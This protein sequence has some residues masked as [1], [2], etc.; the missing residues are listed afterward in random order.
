[1]IIQF[2]LADFSDCFGG[3]LGQHIGDCAPRQKAGRAEKRRLE[4]PVREK[5]LIVHE[6]AVRECI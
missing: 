2:E 3:Q 5:E 4:F 1:M 6:N